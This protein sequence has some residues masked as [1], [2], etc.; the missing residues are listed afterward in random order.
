MRDTDERMSPGKK[1]E[2]AGLGKAPVLRDIAYRGPLNYRFFQILGWICIVAGQ[3]VLMLSAGAR[4]GGMDDF[5]A[6]SEPVLSGVA[7]LAFPFLL[8]FNFS[9]IMNG[10]RTWRAL[11]LKNFFAMAGLWALYAVLLGHFF[12]E[13]LKL[14]STRPEEVPQFVQTVFSR[15]AENGFFCFNIFV[16]L[17]LCTLVMYFLNAR[18]ARFF[19]G[20]RILLFRLLVLLPTAWET[21]SMVLKI[22]AARG[23]LTLSLYLYPLLTVKPPMTFVLFI[24]LA[25]FH[26]TGE[27]RFRR[28]G[29]SRGEYAAFLQTNRNSLSFSVF[30]SLML[31]LISA[32]DWLAV[33]VL[34]SDAGAGT[35]P[36]YRALGF[37]ESR[38]LFLLAL[39]V[40]LFS[41]TR[42]PKNPGLGIATPLAGFVLIILVYLQSIL[43]IL[44]RVKL[45]QVDL[46]SYTPI[47]LSFLEQLR[48]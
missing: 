33:S 20:R 13:G 39:P 17:F 21:A 3:I 4:F 38:Y 47:V 41:Y 31:V 44:H 16:D 29:Y 46:N 12:T 45:P 48:K 28:N 18:P 10:Q 42:K 7:K 34:P 22:L 36:V 5:V 23:D 32:V 14:F 11:I 26:K 30:L 25:V 1:Q 43:Q 8:I 40:L 6:R 9:L 19:S 27:L 2:Q 35:D 37:G 24:V 15:A